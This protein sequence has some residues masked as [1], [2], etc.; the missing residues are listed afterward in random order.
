MFSKL[1]FSQ[2]KI[3][4]KSEICKELRIDFLVED[5]LEYARECAKNGTK[6]FL[7]N[8]PWNQTDNLPDNIIR[9]NSW[10]KI[11]KYLS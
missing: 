4:K 3:K 10:N 5:S 11:I 2:K 7:F 1:H 8:A 9:I 6:V